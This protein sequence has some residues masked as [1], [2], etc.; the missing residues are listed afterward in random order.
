MG[1][2][3]R[4]GLERSRLDDIK[5]RDDLPVVSSI[6][7]THTAAHVLANALFGKVF[8]QLQL[9][10]SPQSEHGMIERSNL[11]DGD[12]GLAGFVSRRR[13]DAV[14]ALPDDVD[15]LIASTYSRSMSASKIHR[16]DLRTDVELDFARLGLSRALFRLLP[17]SCWSRCMLNCDL[18]HDEV[19]HVGSSR[20]MG[21]VI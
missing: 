3:F 19:K 10:Q 18:R 14:C 17:R 4:E 15:H 12:F 1:H 11:L 6:L 13:H 21:Q 16:D 8:E 7:Y 20:T 2:T 5:N 9:P